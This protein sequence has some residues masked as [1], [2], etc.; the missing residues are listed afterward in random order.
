MYFFQS[1]KNLLI[2]LS[3]NFY[4]VT[5]LAQCCWSL[6]NLSKKIRERKMKKCFFFVRA[7]IL[8]RENWKL[9]EIFSSVQLNISIFSNICVWYI[10]DFIIE[11]LFKTEYL[12]S[13]SFSLQLPQQL[14]AHLNC[15]SIKCYSI[16]FDL[17]QFLYISVSIKIMFL[18]MSAIL[19][20]HNKRQQ[21]LNK[22]YWIA[23]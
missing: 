22:C 19:I 3:K 11:L 23:E 17:H 2:N 4:L 12:C 21:I 15:L 5:V 9:F 18:H 6:N 14:Q 7:G 20:Y 16:F 8:F 13:L 10:A 1:N